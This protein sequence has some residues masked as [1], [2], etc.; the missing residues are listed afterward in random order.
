VPIV[1][2]VTME[3]EPLEGAEFTRVELR[4]SHA[5]SDFWETVQRLR[6]AR[7]AWRVAVKLGELLP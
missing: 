4:A 6:H 7:T 3:P 2:R 1:T 5:E